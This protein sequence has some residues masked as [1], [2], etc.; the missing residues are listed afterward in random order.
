[1][2]RLY[3]FIIALLFSS[4]CSFALKHV[5]LYRS[6]VFFK[7]YGTIDSAIKAAYVVGDSLVLSAD[8]FF[9]S[10]LD[11]HTKIIQYQGTISGGDT[12]TIDGGGKLEN[13]LI[14]SRSG[15]I[16]DIIIQNSSLCALETTGGVTTDTFKIGGNSIIRNIITTN[17]GL[18]TIEVVTQA[19]VL[20]DNTKII[21]NTTLRLLRTLNLIIKDNVLISNN[22][23]T[24]PYSRLPHLGTIDAPSQSLS[25][26]G[27]VKIINNTSDSSTTAGICII[28]IPACSVFIGD[29]VTISG[30][31]VLTPGYGKGGAIYFGRDPAYPTAT[32]KTYTFGALNLSNSSADEGGAVY[33]D[34][35]T[36]NLVFNGTYFSNNSAKHGGAI[37]TQ[38][39]LDVK[40]ANF[41]NNQA[42][43]GAAIYLKTAMGGSSAPS[44]SVYNSRI[45]NPIALSGKRQNEVYAS[46]TPAM[47]IP[48]SISFSSNWWGRSDT[49]GVLKESLKGIADL[50]YWAV[51]NWSVKGGVPVVSG[52]TSFPVAA[53]IKLNNGSAFAASSFTMLK[54]IF[55]TDTGSFAPPIAAINSSNIVSSTYKTFKDSALTSRNAHFVAS[56]DADTFRVTVLV[57]SNDTL[58]TKGAIR[59]Q[60]PTQVLVYPNPTSELLHIQAIEI[61]C[62]IALFDVNGKLVKQVDANSNQMSIDIKDL[63]TGLYQ[64]KIAYKDGRVGT[65][66]VMKE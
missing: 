15:T 57:W 28:N 29:S 43:S 11:A 60:A 62:S 41:Y 34:D 46:Y 38:G 59:E 27:K 44:I 35:S 22:H 26:S 17:Y 45:Y 6:G 1:M 30:N 56:I 33:C 64:L 63:A 16:R 10:N 32:Y 66:Q 55:K 54:G 42:D 37:Y 18:A 25:I 39:G 20:M 61:G 53:A 24:M 2:K 12:T 49:I 19:L 65:A 3:V 14:L 51:A 48:P 4:E 7:S 5:D 8:T 50:S 21:N 58:P 13:I 52:D 40:N 23:T 36:I 9:E 31:R 47:S